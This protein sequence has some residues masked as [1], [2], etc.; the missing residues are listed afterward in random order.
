[1]DTTPET[2]AGAAAASGSSNIAYVSGRAFNIGPRYTD[3]QFIG[4]GAYGMVV[5][6]YDTLT[7]QRRAIKKV[8]P[9]EHH[10]FCQ[11]TL[12]EI[13]ILRRFNHPNIVEMVDLF[14]GP[15]PEDVKDVY[16]VL[17]L[18]ET[19]LHEVL[20]SL[21]H[22]GDKLSNTH[23]CFFTYQMLLA[24]KYIHSAN[25]LHRDLKP[26]NMLL[27][28]HNCDLKVCDFGLARVADPAR[29]H[30]GIMTEYVATRWYRAPE[31]MLSAK[32]Y[33]MALDIFSIGCILAEML[34]NKPLFPGKNYVDQLNKI[35]AI[36]GTPQGAD[37][38]SIQ[39][40]RSRQYVENLPFKPKIPW[41]TLY[42]DA[43]PL[44]LDLLE[45]MLAFDPAKRITA[46]QTLEHPYFVDYHF[47]EDEPV[48][49]EP[50]TFDVEFDAL[51][52]EELR[53]LTVQVV[54]KFQVDHPPP[55][56]LQAPD[57]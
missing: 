34:G 40:V 12:R 3:P 54:E 36:C 7:D 33:T 24:V 57:E 53:D 42:P 25:V 38:D 45:R 22:R 47:P 17:N 48:A 56:A 49:L 20:K 4:E 37:L 27:N 14:H 39:N 28:T 9:F 32:N 21:K 2:P 19:D 13:K 55:T 31:V 5:S 23:A 41:T 50:F 35:F 51:P 16:M 18:M 30:A 46:V 26:A 29:D 11:R 43:D 10:T 1:M 52:L 15:S 8:T 44:A 6:S